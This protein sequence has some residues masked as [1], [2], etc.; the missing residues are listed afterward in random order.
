MWLFGFIYNR[1]NYFHV[2]SLPKT[3][4]FIKHLFLFWVTSWRK[5]GWR[6]NRWIQIAVFLPQFIASSGWSRKLTQTVKINID[7]NNLNSLN[8]FQLFSFLPRKQK[9]GHNHNSFWKKAQIHFP[10]LGWSSQVFTTKTIT[11]IHCRSL[12]AW[13]LGLRIPEKWSFLFP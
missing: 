13:S 6:D 12:S 11:L 2:Y 8:K 5:K 9:S 1:V 4:H 10:L 7:E 3:D